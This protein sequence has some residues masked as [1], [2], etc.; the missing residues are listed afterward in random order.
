MHKVYLGIGGNLGDREEN[1][2]STLRLIAEWVGTVEA[3]SPIFE[4]E[5]WGFNHAQS[6]LN[7]V[8]EVTTSLEPMQVLEVCKGI[9]VALGREKPKHSGYAGRT[10]DVDI[11]FYDD[12]IFNDSLLTIPHAK[13][14]ERLFVLKPLVQIAPDLIHPLL[15]KNIVQLLEECT[16]VG[17]V[18][19]YG[20]LK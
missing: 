11:L 9:E 3:V 5:P 1:L 8:V 19:E 4:S 12:M 18:W 13:L 2:N 16:D 10:A 7:Q 15:Q 20:K 6:F 17:G 14:H